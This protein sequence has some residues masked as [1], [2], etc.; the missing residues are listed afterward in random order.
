VRDTVLRPIH[1][2]GQTAPVRYVEAVLLFA[3]AL[4]SYA[5][6]LDS[7][8]RISFAIARGVFAETAQRTSRSAA[9]GTVMAAAT[10]FDHP[11]QPFSAT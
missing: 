10:F 7:P 1:E 11:R 5:S 6:E 2:I 8:R 4:V 9:D 3:T